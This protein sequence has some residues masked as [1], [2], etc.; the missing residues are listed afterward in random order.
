MK[1]SFKTKKSIFIKDKNLIL[2][3][4][5]NSFRSG[6]HLFEN[7]IELKNEYSSKV[8]YC[9]TSKGVF[10]GWGFLARGI[11]KTY[12][13]MLFVKKKFRRLGIGTK[14]IKLLSRRK[15]NIEV[16]SHDKISRKFFQSIIKKDPKLIIL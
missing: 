16:Y 12:F 4:K 11:D 3:F 6:G 1:L 10:C 14:I 15:K 2:K 13:I 8:C 7:F 5:R 9:E